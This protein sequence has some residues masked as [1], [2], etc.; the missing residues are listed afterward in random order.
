MRRSTVSAANNSDLSIRRL[1]SLYC[2]LSSLLIAYKHRSDGGTT[3]HVEVP[4]SVLS[5]MSRSSTV[6]TD[7]KIKNSHPQ[8][9]ARTGASSEAL[10]FSA[11]K[12]KDS[13]PSF[14]VE[15]TEPAPAL[16]EYPQRIPF[17]EAHNEMGDPNG[18]DMDFPIS[19]AIQG[20]ASDPGAAFKDSTQAPGFKCYQP[21]YSST[22]DQM[23]DSAGTYSNLWADVGD[24]SLN[25]GCE[26]PDRPL[27]HG[28]PSIHPSSGL[29]IGCDYMFES[30]LMNGPSEASLHQISADPAG[31]DL[32]KA[33]RQASAS[34]ANDYAHAR[35]PNLNN[36]APPGID[37]RNLSLFG[38]H[39]R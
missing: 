25:L 5:S 27:A 15:T 18:N 29:D 22:Q 20:Q 9:D 2:N 10:N 1:V 30:S 38:Q 31:L 6:G 13:F 11:T 39:L 35:G 21:S 16:G 32:Q 33:R 23:L 3:I 14:K 4:P 8:I 24:L 17:D 28:L 12:V 37:P 26:R 36:T 7:V 34:Y 19:L